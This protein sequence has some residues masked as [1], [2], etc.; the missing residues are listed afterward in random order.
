MQGRQHEFKINITIECFLPKNVKYFDKSLLIRKLL[1][2]DVNKFSRLQNKETSSSLQT[3]YHL[4]GANII[5]GVLNP[6]FFC[7]CIMLIVE[8]QYEYI[9]TG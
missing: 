6:S 1:D 2:N 4:S 7:T 3:M 8:R 9:V 5:N